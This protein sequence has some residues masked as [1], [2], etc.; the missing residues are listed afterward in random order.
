MS[1]RFFVYPI[2]FLALTQLIPL[3]GGER[4]WYVAQICQLL[5]TLL[6]CCGAIYFSKDSVWV[7]IAWALFAAFVIAPAVLTSLA[8]GKEVS[9]YWRGAAMFRQLAGRVAWGR[10]GRLYRRYA[11]ALRLVARGQTEEALLALDQLATQPMPLM[12]CGV[13]RIWKLSLLVA[14]RQWGPAVAF[15][16]SA[17][18]WGT[19]G[20]ATQ[21]RL[22]AARALAETGQIERAQRSLQFV[23]LSPRTLGAR[24]TQL[25][26]TRVCVAAL[27]GDATSVESLLRQ[28]EYVRR[29]RRFARFAA[30]WRGRC[31]LARG[32]RETAMQGLTRALGLTQMK[33]HLWRDAI[34]QQLTRAQTEELPTQWAA[35]DPS[36]AHGQALLQR[37][38]KDTVVW[39][40]L[41]YM[42]RP[43]PVTLA[44]LVILTVVYLVGDVFLSSDLQDKFQLW[45]GN[46]SATVQHGEWWRVFTALF[47]HANWLHLTM[48]GAG[49]WI[50][51]T[52]VEK[53]M[54]RWR[55]LMVFLL[56]GA[57]GNLASA[58]VAHYDVAI[59]ASG[60][61]FG[62]I[63]AFAVAVWRLRSPM[64]HSLRRR[65]LV[66]LAL[67]VATDFTIGGLEPHVD[68]LAHVGGFV[69]G[70]LITLVLYRRPE[71]VAAQ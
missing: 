71:R 23:A 30:Y 35:Q 5:V 8:A 65:L 4:R 20:Q 43:E 57:L 66:V 67:M 1:Q 63:G 17:H 22:F 9:G 45:A 14:L 15:Y 25:W 52:A 56:A 61:I 16:E 68:N 62:V 40:A 18:D 48:N 3:L 53:T 24:Q 12:I 26:A 6:A 2:L 11:A 7:S 32:D 27:A 39:R 49:L 41:M 34:A 64:Y 42:G 44:L 69:A 50:F 29:S 58:F 10:T 38:E 33:N 37:A 59:G 70:I 54:G 55:L 51:G 19:L 47:L 31:A 60:G 28:R 21:A 13:V 36:Y 46:S